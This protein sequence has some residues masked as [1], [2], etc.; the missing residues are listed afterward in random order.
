MYDHESTY[1]NAIYNSTVVFTIYIILILTCISVWCGLS[2]WTGMNLSSV[3][4]SLNPTIFNYELKSSL[5][6]PIDPG[7]NLLLTRYHAST[8]V[9]FLALAWFWRNIGM[10]TGAVLARLLMITRLGI[11]SQYWAGT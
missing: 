11:G 10:D 4:R 8:D 3:I 6:N 2:S 5:L 1:Q 9:V 7:G